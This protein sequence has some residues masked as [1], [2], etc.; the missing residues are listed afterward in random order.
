MLFII[1]VSVVVISA[2]IQVLAG[3]IKDRL[4]TS[5]RGLPVREHVAT[6]R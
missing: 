5:N 6:T 4:L 3:D 2:S 1:S